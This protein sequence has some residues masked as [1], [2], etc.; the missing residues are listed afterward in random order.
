MPRGRC[1]KRG[2]GGDQTRPLC[3]GGGEVKTVVN[4]LIEVEGYRVGCGDV[5]GRRQQFDRGRLDCGESRS[6]E[7]TG[8]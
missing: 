7:I 8:E 3:Q 2:I 6:G 5:A 1:S 4:R